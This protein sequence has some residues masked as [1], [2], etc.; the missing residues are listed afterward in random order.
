[1]LFAEGVG[2]DSSVGTA[3]GYGLYGLGIE[4]RWGRNFSHTSRLA[5]GPTQP[6]VSMGTASFPG[7]KRP[8][9]GADHPAPSSAEVTNE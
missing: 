6:P 7:L 5:M 2:Q 8:G 9:R 1:M 3:S 4:I